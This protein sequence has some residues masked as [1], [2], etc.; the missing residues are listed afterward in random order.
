MYTASDL[1]KGLR[2]KIDN[3]PYVVTEFNFVKPGKGAL[4]LQ[5]KKHAHR[6]PV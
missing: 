1:R 2:L 3:D 4:P 6:K 5:I